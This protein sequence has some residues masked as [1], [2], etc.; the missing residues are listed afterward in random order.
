MFYLKNTSMATVHYDLLGRYLSAGDVCPIS[1]I[2]EVDTI[3]LSPFVIKTHSLV[4][5]EAESVFL[6]PSGVDATRVLPD[7]VRLHVK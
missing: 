5:S 6:L 7:R 1:C 4:V 3:L 2:I